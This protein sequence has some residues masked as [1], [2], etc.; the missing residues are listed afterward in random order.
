MERSITPIEEKQVDDFVIQADFKMPMYR[1]AVEWLKTKYAMKSQ[2]QKT[3]Q[4]YKDTL[5]SFDMFLQGKGLRLESE[6]REVALLAQ[7]WVQESR[8]GRDVSTSTINQRYAII[9]SFYKFAITYGACEHNPISYCE[10]PQRQ[11]HHDAP[12]LDKQYIEECMKRIDR[13]TREGKRD[14]TLLTLAFMTGRRLS[15]LTGVQWQHVTM[16]GKT[17]IVKWVRCKGNK[18]MTDV[19]PAKVASILLT[20]L[21]SEYGRNLERIKPESYLFQSHSRRNQ[22]GRLSAQ[23]LSDICMERLGVSQVHTTRHSFAVNSEKAG[24]SLSE[25]GDQLGHSN[26]ATTSNYMKQKRRNI[27]AHADTLS[28]MLGIEE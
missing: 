23:A 2:S 16:Q 10:R 9:S 11:V 13:T 28:D 7:E 5:Q 24:Y 3:Q 4:A 17:I 21:Q 8:V 18:T 6:P 25:I 27:H 19:L 26:L 15:E 1:A 14:Y 22:A 12:A 20:F